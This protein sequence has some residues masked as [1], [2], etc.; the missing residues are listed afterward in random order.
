VHTITLLSIAKKPW[1]NQPEKTSPARPSRY[2][3][4]TGEIT[5]LLDVRTYVCKPGTLK[6]H[7]DLYEKLGK[8]PQVRHLG[9][10]LL[11]A[12]CETGNPNEYI[13]IWCYKNAADREER[14]AGLWV[15]P[16]WLSYV[17]QSAELGALESQQ[18]KLMK[19]V[20][21]FPL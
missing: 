20:D 2:K 11:Y 14:R 5:M 4:I 16:E 1:N 21:F 3:K 10:P 15:D 13:H 6:A 19:P 17:K 18:N 8:T 12:A 9:M 7:L